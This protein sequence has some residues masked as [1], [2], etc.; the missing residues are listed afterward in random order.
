VSLIYAGFRS[1]RGELLAGESC[2]AR[3][4]GVCADI[5]EAEF[6]MNRFCEKKEQNVGRLAADVEPCENPRIRHRMEYARRCLS[7]GV[8]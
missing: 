2:F 3:G 4:F 1:E 8:R 7:A 5:G 6:P